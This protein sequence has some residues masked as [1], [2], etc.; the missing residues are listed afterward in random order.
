MAW[1]TKNLL[2]HG[3][4]GPQ[5]LMHGGGMREMWRQDVGGR[6]RKEHIHV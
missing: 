4:K 6:D 3:W 5:A 1:F 2:V